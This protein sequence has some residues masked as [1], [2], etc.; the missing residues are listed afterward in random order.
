M[1][2]KSRGSNSDSNSQKVYRWGMVTS[3]LSI[4]LCLYDLKI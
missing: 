4:I 1:V 3:R 2:Q